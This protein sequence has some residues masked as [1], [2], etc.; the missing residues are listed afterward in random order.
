[1]TISEYISKW[2]KE[3]RKI[4]IDTNHVSDGSDKYGLFKSPARDVKEFTDESYEITEFY[5]FL[6][7]QSAS[8]KADRVD[9]DEWMEE[10]AYWADD[11]HC[12]Y[13]YPKLDG[14]RKV[15]D[16]RMTAS[17]YPME[18]KDRDALYQVTLSITYTRE[19]E[20]KEWRG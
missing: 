5:Q 10:L 15:S 18:I 9:S 8:S 7:R 2:L 1:M 12:W 14:Q 6:I 16:I 20:D 3:Y 19:R 4:E 11:Y 17:P 13:E